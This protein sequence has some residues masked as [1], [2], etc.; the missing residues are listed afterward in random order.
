MKWWDNI[1]YRVVKNTSE[2]IQ[3]LDTQP[4][5]YLL[6]LYEG[7]DIDDYIEKEFHRVNRPKK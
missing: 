3:S 5:D 1:I 2:N 6:M 4:I 7:L